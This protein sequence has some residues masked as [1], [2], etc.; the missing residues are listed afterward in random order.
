[1]LRY[2]VSGR[3]DFRK[4]PDFPAK[5]LNWDIFVLRSGKV[6]FDPDDV[7]LATPPNTNLW[8]IAPGI[9]YCWRPTKGTCTRTVFSFSHLPPILQEEVGPK[10]VLARRITEENLR[11]I[12]VLA[13]GIRDDFTCLNQFSS[14]IFERA[15]IDLTLIIL[16]KIPLRSQ[17][18][19]EEL[20]RNRVEQAISWYSYHMPQAPKVSLVARECHI[21][22]S[23]MRRLF[24]QVTGTTPHEVFMQLQIQRACE[25]LSGSSAPLAEIASQC[26]FQSSSD[27][28]RVFARKHHISPNVWRHKVSERSQA[29]TQIKPLFTTGK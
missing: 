29:T 1:M 3:R 24:L 22:E 10:G 19:I 27:F 2:L 15:L 16:S 21:A 4:S 8:V 7:A 20:A 12:A 6:R 28:C 14:L 9:R 23:H 17:T 25:L 13:E 26:G 11:R 18:R 5:R